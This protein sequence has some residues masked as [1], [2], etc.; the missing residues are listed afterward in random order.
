MKKMALIALV[1]AAAAGALSAPATAQMKVITM[2]EA[3]PTPQ[4]AP[5]AVPVCSAPN[6]TVLA[7]NDRQSAQLADIDHNLATIAYYL[8]LIEGD[9]SASKAKPE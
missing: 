8:C 9:L 5:A 1:T 7:G 2:P 6:P 3:S 4:Q